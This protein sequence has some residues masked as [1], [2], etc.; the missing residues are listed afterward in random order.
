MRK[1]LTATA[2]S[3]ALMTGVAHAEKYQA[4]TWLAPSHILTSVGYGPFLADVKAATNG[5]VDFEL[6]SSGSLVPAQT[7]LG[8]LGDNVAQLGLV[9]TSYT[10]SEPAD[11]GPDQRSCLRGKERHGYRLCPDRDGA[12]EQK[13]TG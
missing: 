11:L 5:K 1:I 6:Y 3:L 12:D 10:P 9:A 8:A 7:T 13:D 2:A 4:T